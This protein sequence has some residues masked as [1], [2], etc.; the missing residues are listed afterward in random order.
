MVY[1]EDSPSCK[2][3]KNEYH[4]IAVKEVFVLGKNSS[5]TKIFI[6]WMF[7]STIGAAMSGNLVTINIFNEP[8][9]GGRCIF[10]L[11]TKIFLTVRQK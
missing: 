11:R 6:S 7:S 2:S 1:L 4:E 3:P 8:Y 10:A 9:V 5:K